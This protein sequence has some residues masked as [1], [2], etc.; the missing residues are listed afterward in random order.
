MTDTP[1]PFDL[2]RWVDDVYERIADR[3]EKA[4]TILKGGAPI[5]EALEE[6]YNLGRQHSERQL[7][8]AKAELA[9][10]NEM[11][12][13]AEKA[14]TE[15]HLESRHSDYCTR[16]NAHPFP[17]RHKCCCAIGPAERVRDCLRKILEKADD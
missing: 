8:Q 12:G 16:R 3:Y 4:G 15:L 17:P 5:G 1:Q 10:A 13:K 14:L 7:A 6:A 11:L 2:D 9:E